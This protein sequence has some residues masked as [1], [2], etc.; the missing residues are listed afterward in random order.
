[1]KFKMELVE[2]EDRWA[3]R[4]SPVCQTHATWWP[5]LTKSDDE[6]QKV[7]D[8]AATLIVA[9]LHGGRITKDEALA[10]LGSLKLGNWTS[11]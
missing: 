9:D 7:D 5:C 3:D 10:F 4:Y 6:C 11:A 2:E 1:M 8:P